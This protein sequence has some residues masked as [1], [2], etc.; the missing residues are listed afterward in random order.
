MSCSN[1]VLS[2][3]WSFSLYTLHKM[4]DKLASPMTPNTAK[5]INNLLVE[6]IDYYD[7]PPI[8][9]ETANIKARLIFRLL[10]IIL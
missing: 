7:M 1:L 4:L 3:G 10:F 9:M 6:L 8:Q 5:G 2:S